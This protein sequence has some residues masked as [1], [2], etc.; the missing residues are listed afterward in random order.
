M[1]SWSGGCSLPTFDEKPARPLP[2]WSRVHKELKRR[3]VTLLLLWEEYRA[4]HTDGYG[5]SQDQ[6]GDLFQL[7]EEVRRPAAERDARSSNAIALHSG[8]L[9]VLANS[10]ARRIT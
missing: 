3:A 9:P 8:Y 1:P 2:D 10:L 4:E 7:E 6:P 5:Y